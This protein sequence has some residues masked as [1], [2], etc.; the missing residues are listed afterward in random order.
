MDKK[1]F[2]FRL[3]SDLMLEF[4]KIADILGFHNYEA[5]ELA[6]E[7]WVKKNKQEAQKKLDMYAQKGIEINLESCN[8]NLDLKIFQKTDVMLAK[9]ELNHLSQEYRYAA[10]EDGYAKTEQKILLLKAI[11]RARPVLV[12]SRDPEL[13]KLVETIT[14]QLEASAEMPAE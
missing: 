14:K 8:V 12:K 3:R 13:A 5:A 7:E 11:Q 2:S 10:E 9:E 4:S 6:F 1:Q